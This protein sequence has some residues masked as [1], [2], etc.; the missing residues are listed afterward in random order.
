MRSFLKISAVVSTTTLIAALAFP[1][2]AMAVELSSSSASYGDKVSLIHNDYGKDVLIKSD[3]S[4]D[5][6]QKMRDTLNDQS[7]QIEE[8][9][10][11]SGSGSSASAKE[12][13]ELKNRVKEQDR[14]L[15]SL[16]RQVEELKRNSG[17]SS[18][19]NSSEISNLKQMVNNQDRDMDQLKRTVEDLSRKVK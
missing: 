14:E 1:A 9:K 4:I 17:S 16:G 7:R 3:I 5:E 10:R 13:D 18:N 6:L 8:F 2:S 11:N 15:E 19:S 12:I